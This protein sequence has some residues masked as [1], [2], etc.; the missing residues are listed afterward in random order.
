MFEAGDNF[1]NYN[2][3]NHPDIP[4]NKFVLDLPKGQE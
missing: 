4:Y 1:E 3:Q 2:M